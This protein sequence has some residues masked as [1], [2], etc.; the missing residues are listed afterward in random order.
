MTRQRTGGFPIKLLNYME[1]AKPIVAFENIA[2]GLQHDHSA[3]LLPSRAGSSELAHALLSLR[4]DS[5]RAARLGVA[6]RRRLET[7][8]AWRNLA[9]E[10]L[11]LVRE[12]TENSRLGTVHAK[13]VDLEE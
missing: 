6:A 12:I 4:Q 1:A 9:E 8:H 2:V 7:H 13:P 5:G 11:A 10:T 3:W